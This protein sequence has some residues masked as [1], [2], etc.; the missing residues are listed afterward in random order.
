VGTERE[1]DRSEPYRCGYVA[2]AGQPNVGKS[3]LL[4]TLV[5]TH[6]SIVTPKAQTTRER[7]AGLVTTE[8]Y[9]VLFIDAPGLIEPRY[10]LQE[11]MRLA[12]AASLEEADVI[13]YVVD[14]TRPRTLPDKETVKALTSLPAPVLIAINKSDLI[15]SAEQATLIAQA[16]AS[17]FP[18]HAV[19]A[20]SGSGLDRL[21]QRLVPLLPE[22]PPLFPTDETATQP[23]RFFAQEFVRETCMELLREEVPYAITCQVD[24]FREDGDPIY[25]RVIIYVERESQKGIVIGKGGSSIKQ[26]GRLSRLKIEDLVGGKVYLELH[27]KVMQDWRRK[28]PRL[29]QLGFRLPPPNA[30]GGQRAG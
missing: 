1:N 5:G 14:A 13:T 30:S 29:E 20:V 19:S 10:A 3:T 4:N 16:E 23:V 27:V 2:L 18:T 6:L 25:V 22:S 17:G 9:Q 11:A 26:I 21:V 24:E 28:R 8:A 7:I 15:E 12:A